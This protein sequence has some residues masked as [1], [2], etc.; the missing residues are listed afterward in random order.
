MASD[1]PAAGGGSILLRLLSCPDCGEIMAL[2]RIMPDEPGYQR[3]TF[4]CETCHRSETVLVRTARE[5]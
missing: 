2:T 3:L 4:R 5:S 1:D